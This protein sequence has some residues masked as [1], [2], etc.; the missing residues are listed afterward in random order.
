M[1]SAKKFEH[2]RP[3]TAASDVRN[4]LDGTPPDNADQTLKR[5]SAFGNADKVTPI[6]FRNRQQ[7]KIKISKKGIII[8]FLKLQHKKHR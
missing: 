1:I 7:I 6:V 5:I 2:R 3:S 8:M 4:C